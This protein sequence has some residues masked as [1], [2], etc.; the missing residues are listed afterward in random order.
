MFK[1]DWAVFLTS[2]LVTLSSSSSSSSSDRLW[3]WK[4]TMLWGVD[5][6]LCT[7]LIFLILFRN[8]ML[9]EDVETVFLADRTE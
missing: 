1:F 6:Q 7:G 5:H 9:R 4:K 8:G 3:T 2:I